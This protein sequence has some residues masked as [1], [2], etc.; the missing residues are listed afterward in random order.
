M[1]FKG[2]LWSI[3]WHRQF[4]VEISRTIYS[5]C[6]LGY[7]ITNNTKLEK[8]ST[9]EKMTPP[10]GGPLG[11]KNANFSTIEFRAEPPMFF[12]YILVVYE[13]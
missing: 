3:G 12:I 1:T 11:P 8:I 13:E 6:I 7:P 9:I 2:T 10:Q 5:V 4:F